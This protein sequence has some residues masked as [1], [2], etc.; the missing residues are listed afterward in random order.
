MS[1]VSPS[2]QRH[3]AWLSLPDRGIVRVAGPEANKLLQGLITNDMGL[4]AR[5]RAIHAGLLTPQGKVLL[6]FLV[7]GDGEDYLL[8]MSRDRVDEL[9]RRLNLYKL[10]AKVTIS[11]LSSDHLVSASEKGPAASSQS[12]EEI[13]FPDPRNHE[14][15]WRIVAQRHSDSSAPKLTSDV[16]DVRRI[17]LGIPECGKDYVP[18]EVFPHEAMLDQ[19]NGISFSKGC[20]VGQEIVSR[21][22][23]RG[24]ARSRFLM[25]SS[26][27]LLP[28]RG[29]EIAAEG[30]P[31]GAMGSSVGAQGLA[32]VRLDRLT[33]TLQ[34]GKPVKAGPITL[35]FAK[36]AYASFAIDL[37][38]SRG[39]NA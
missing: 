38:P 39:A 3:W 8:D 7:V 9:I 21:M 14:L 20:Y 33:E 34:A 31:I 29:T 35:T 19:L 10:R 13:M 30:R 18:G 11:D 36:P 32:L 26:E 5:Q 25:V 27:G 15:G 28:P 1:D 23:H 12:G 22:E 17:D 16:Y 4:L 24:T 2:N 6:E 37:P